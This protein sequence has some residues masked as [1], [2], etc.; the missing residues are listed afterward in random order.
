MTQHDPL[1]EKDAQERRDEL[2]RQWQEAFE[3]L[4][5]LDANGM[6]DAA[7]LCEA[8][9]AALERQMLDVKGLLP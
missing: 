1:F 7:D 4:C 8:R 9:L 3:H 6:S 5:A 2:Q